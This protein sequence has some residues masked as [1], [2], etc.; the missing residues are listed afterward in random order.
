MYARQVSMEL[1]PN[2]RTEFVKKLD[3]DILPLL[4]KQQGFKDMITFVSP[5]SKF[6]FA[7]S[8]WDS[9]QSAED[10]SQASYAEV[11]KML[12]KLIQGTPKVKTFEVAHSTLQ[13]SAS[14]QKAA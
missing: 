2:S 3:S 9:K 6:T 8:L 7:V 13:D 12:S 4:R 11:T 5:D 10:Y 14:R 1:N